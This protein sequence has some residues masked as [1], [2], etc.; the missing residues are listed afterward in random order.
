[1]SP[2][3]MA[4]RARLLAEMN[5]IRI[6]MNATMQRYQSGPPKD[7]MQELDHFTNLSKHFDEISRKFDNL[8]ID[9]P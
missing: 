3:A 8:L 9:T 5:Q 1:M 2:E 6:E 4:E 7:R